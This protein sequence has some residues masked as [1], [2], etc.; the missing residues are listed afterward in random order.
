MEEANI[1]L[2]DYIIPIGSPCEGCAVLVG[3]YLITAGH[4]L[5]KSENTTISFKK[6]KYKLNKDNCVYF[7]SMNDLSWNILGNDIAVYK[8]DSINSPIELYKENLLLNDILHSISYKVFVSKIDNDNNVF[9][10][11]NTTDH[12]EIIE[13]NGK[14]VDIKGNFIACEMSYPLRKGSSGSPIFYKG[15]LACILSAGDESREICIF[16]N[17]QSIMQL[18]LK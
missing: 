6:K 10:W 15:K 9:G 8:L 13:C 12:T 3:N 17:A 4:V 2:N 14:V 16:Q 11:L 18:L 5:E 7:S 1:E